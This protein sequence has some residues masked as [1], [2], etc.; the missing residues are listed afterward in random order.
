M[1]HALSEVWRILAADGVLL[2][3]RPYLPFG[4]LELVAGNEVRILGRLDEAEFDP[5]DP[6]ADNAVAE[7]MRRG[8]FA[9]QR[10][11]SFHSSSYWD[12][13]AELREYLKDWTDVARL[14]RR[15]AG[16]ARTALR[17]AGSSGRLRLKTY[18]VVN[19]MRKAPG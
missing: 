4:P 8:L 3:I 17:R 1:V 9:L 15:L 2:D 10:T 13:V 18:V 12:S 5:G 11:G 14:P 19:V 7:V 16:E 6:A